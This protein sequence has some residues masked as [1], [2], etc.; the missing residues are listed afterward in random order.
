MSGHTSVLLSI[1]TRTCQS[2]FFKNTW[3]RDKKLQKKNHNWGAVW[4]EI[5]KSV[6]QE[7]KRKKK[8]ITETHRSEGAFKTTT[9]KKSEKLVHHHKS[10][11]NSLEFFCDESKVQTYTSNFSIAQLETERSEEVYQCISSKQPVFSLL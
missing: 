9:K 11:G 8:R 10:A 6:E 7:G 4:S 2:V 5:E 1:G 3:A